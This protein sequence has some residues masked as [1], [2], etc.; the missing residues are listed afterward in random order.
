LITLE[1]RIGGRVILEAEGGLEMTVALAER[2]TVGGLEPLGDHPPGKPWSVEELSDFLGIDHKH[3]RRLIDGGK[4][5]CIR[6]GRRVL[7]ADAE[8][9][10]V[11]SEGC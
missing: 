9:R 6:L 11:A 1:T 7:I 2:P 10:R 4:V 3:L 5:A 8:A